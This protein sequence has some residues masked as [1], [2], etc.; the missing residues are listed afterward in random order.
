MGL[1]PGRCLPTV[2]NFHQ[3]IM[4][5]YLY[6]AGTLGSVVGWVIFVPLLWFLVF[7]VRWR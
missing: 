6:A 4:D 1:L 5:I 2:S 7:M 3:I